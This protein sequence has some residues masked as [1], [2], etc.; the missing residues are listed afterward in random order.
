LVDNGSTLDNNMKGQGS[1]ELNC[2]WYHDEEIFKDGWLIEA[3]LNH[4]ARE[5]L[6]SKS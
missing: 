1:E 5:L 2:L 4:A 6:I 3:H